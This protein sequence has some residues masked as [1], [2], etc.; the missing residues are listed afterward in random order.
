MLIGYV[1]EDDVASTSR[2]FVGDV[3]RR[4]SSFMSR[5]A[6]L[7]ERA[8]SS[9]R[10]AGLDRASE[11]VKGERGSER[12]SALCN[13]ANC[14]N[15]DARGHVSRHRWRGGKKSKEGGREGG[16]SSRRR[17]AAPTDKPLLS[18][19]AFEN[20]LLILLIFI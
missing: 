5:R 14:A 2:I 12:W 8:C 19:V 1:I 9:Q 17:T 15:L 20:L 6:S 3:S 10:K 18:R 11:G 16:G 7:V 4:D 13:L